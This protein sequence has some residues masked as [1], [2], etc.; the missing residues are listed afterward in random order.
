MRAFVDR[1][2]IEWDHPSIVDL[3]LLMAIARRR[4]ILIRNAIVM[5]QSNQLLM[6]RDCETE[7][8]S[9]RDGLTNLETRRRSMMTRC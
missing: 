4:M 8:E 6:S 5:A 7:S 9:E 1:Q 2:V 3:L